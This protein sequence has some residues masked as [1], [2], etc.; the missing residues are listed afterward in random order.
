MRSLHPPRARP[1][2][3]EVR[4]RRLA[5]GGSGRDDNNKFQL[6]NKVFFT[7][8]PSQLYPTVHDHIKKALEEHI[9]S[10]SHRSDKFS[11]FNKSATDNVRK[12][13]NI[14][15]SHHVF[16]TSSALEAMERTIQ[17][18]VYKYSYHFVNGS[19]SRE[20]YQI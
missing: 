5:F 3:S 9:P 12:L 8:G 2:L 19:F 4:L 11:E 7:V 16:F 17:N 15:K 1:A 6:M 20:F 10:L 14:P 13:L 18:T